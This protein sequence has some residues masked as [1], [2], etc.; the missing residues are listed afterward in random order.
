MLGRDEGLISLSTNIRIVL[1]PVL[2]HFS[3]NVLNTNKFRPLFVVHQKPY[4]T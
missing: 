2:R 4:F 3:P 1:T